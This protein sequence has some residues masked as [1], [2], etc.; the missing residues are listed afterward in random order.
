MIQRRDVRAISISINHSGQT[1]ASYD[2]VLAEAFDSVTPAEPAGYSYDGVQVDHAYDGVQ[3]D[4]AYDGVSLDPV[5]EA[6]QVA[7]LAG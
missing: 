3:V 2:N 5:A 1:S 4:H 7:P 6:G